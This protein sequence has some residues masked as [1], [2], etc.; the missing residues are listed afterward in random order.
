MRTSRSILPQEVRWLFRVCVLF[1]LLAGFRNAEAQST[2]HSDIEWQV[3]AA[4]LYKFG[5]Y[6]EWPSSTFQSPDSPLRIGIIGAD[7]IA[8]ELQKIVAGRSINGRS[9]AVRKM[10]RG[11]P[12]SGLNILFIGSSNTGQLAETLAA[13]KGL[14]ILTVTESDDGLTIGSMINFVVVNGKLRFEVAPKAATSGNLAI[15]ARL[16]AVAYKVVPGSS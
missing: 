1:L 3:K 14:P 12:V 6:I 7:A 16:L 5:S 15:S 10:Q 8:D 9:V 4:Y 13:V 11:D 2:E